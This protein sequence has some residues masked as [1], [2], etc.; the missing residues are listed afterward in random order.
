MA[1]NH[2][3][4]SPAGLAE[5]LQPKLSTSVRHNLETLACSL[6]LAWLHGRKPYDVWHYVDATYFSL[7]AA[8]LVSPVPV[9]CHL[10]GKVPGYDLEQDVSFLKGLVV[11]LKRALLDRAIRRGMLGSV[12]ETEATGPYNAPLFGPHVYQIPYA[13]NVPQK[14]LSQEPARQKMLGIS[15]T[16]FV[17][18]LFGTHRPGKDYDTVVRG[19]A[20]SGREICL[21]FAGK[22]ISEN[23]PA[24]VLSR[25]NFSNAVVVEKFIRAE[26]APL[27]FAACD[28][29]VLPYYE[30]YTKGSATYS[31]RHLNTHVRPSRRKPGS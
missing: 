17:L 28:A 26:E 1:N 22:T 29:V 4:A 11:R 20:L 19:A 21:L 5:W 23:D 25:H 18:L 7:F 12:C 8:A 15:P 27:Y 10:W 24:A 9:I 13:V 2:F 30:G 31:S 6:R 3:R 16:S 14:P